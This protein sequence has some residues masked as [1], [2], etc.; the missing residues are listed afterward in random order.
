MKM[1]IDY[2]KDRIKPIEVAITYLGNPI[3][4]TTTGSWYKSPFRQEKTASFLVNNTKGFHDFGTSE[5]YDIISFA[6]R[7]FNTDFKTAIKILCKDFGI[8]EDDYI[9]ADVHKYVVAKRHEDV[10]IQEKL[11]EWYNLTFGQLCM[12]YKENKRLLKYIDD[13]TK[14]VIYD[15]D[16]KLEI[17]TE[18]FMEMSENKE[19]LYQEYKGVKI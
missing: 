13:N 10:E 16:V 4:I 7:L 6:E 9:E 18:I 3:R 2:I 11:N 15:E 1:N 8:I 14:N 17:I 5:H 12:K 19:K